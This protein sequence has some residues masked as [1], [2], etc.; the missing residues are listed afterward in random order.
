MGTSPCPTRDG[1]KGP[2]HIF[3]LHRVSVSTY[4]GSRRLLTFESKAKAEESEAYMKSSIYTFYWHWA[5][6][7]EP[8][9][10]TQYRADLKFQASRYMADSHGM[11]PNRILP[12]LV[13]D[14]QIKSLA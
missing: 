3:A 6:Y 8:F 13:D 4:I 12:L 5:G 2:S 14:T 7:P 1:P 10:M 11:Q 9:W